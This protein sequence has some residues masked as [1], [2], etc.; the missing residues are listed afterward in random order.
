[1]FARV[2]H[3]LDSEDIKFDADVLDTVVKATYP[4]LRKCIN[5]VQMNS[6]DGNLHSPEKGDTGEQDYKLQMVDLFK[7]KKYQE[8][9]KLV[10]GKLRA[11][12]IEEMYRW[13]YDNISLFGEGDIQDSAVLV[14]KQGLVDHFVVV[15]P[16]INLAATMVRLARLNK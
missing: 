11:E 9:R 15:D 2:V 4:D 16:E 12:E 3:I 1:M 6:L 14:I 10:C 13:M 8:A 5:M 7:A